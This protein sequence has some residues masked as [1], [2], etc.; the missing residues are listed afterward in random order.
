MT[1]R[2]ANSDA[3]LESELTPLPE[4]AG[5][6]L[7]AARKQ[8]FKLAFSAQQRGLPAV[9][10]LH[11][12]GCDSGIWAG[13]QQDLGE[14]L[15]MYA[16]DLPG[17][18]VNANIDCESVD[19]FYQRFLAEVEPQLP[20]RYAVLGWSL[21]GTLAARIAQR[22][23]RVTQLFTIATNPVFVQQSRWS[24]G[25]PRGAFNSFAKSVEEDGERALQR[26]YALQTGGASSSRRELRLLQSLAKS[27]NFNWQQLSRSLQWLATQ[28]LRDC[29][30]DLR[31]PA[32]HFFGQHD[33][34]VPA[35]A[36]GA[37][38]LNFPHHQVH[39]F[40]A[41][42]H[43]PFCSERERWNKLLV[44]A[45]KSALHSPGSD[46]LDKHAVAMAFSKAAGQYEQ[47][48]LLQRAVGDRLF[49]RLQPFLQRVSQSHS[50]EA[51]SVLDCG[52]GTGL[53]ARQLRT[54]LPAAAQVVEMDLSMGMLHHSKAHLQQS[55]VANAA[56]VLADFDSLPFKN[57]AF[58]AIFA[59][60]SLQWCTDFGGVLQR[61][62]GLL[63]PGGELVLS[64][65]AQGS[66]RELRE[67]W[68]LVD[69]TEHVN[70]FADSNDLYQAA[71]ACGLTLRA[72]KQ[73]KEQLH[74][75]NSTE[76]MASV[77]G[78][79]AGNHLRSRSRGLL[80]VQRYR[81]FLNALNLQRSSDRAL[82]LTYN[83]VLMHLQQAQ[84]HQSQQQAQPNQAK[85]LAAN[86]AAQVAIKK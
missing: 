3:A 35:E 72:F 86:N 4:K 25:M 82:P 48:A 50:E 19:V 74:F 43:L 69:Q 83:V 42:A 8:S 26:F 58:D 2:F 39:Q 9:L 61:L 10:L 78:I 55:G 47:H 29:Y 36:A 1:A 31:V 14:Q 6:V 18:G 60:F 7:A 45:L 67:A 22:S 66:L 62:S 71:N 46:T 56:F 59:N 51:I 12:W 11:G 28:D 16:L 33:A 63:K 41:S 15:D 17:H 75:A 80:G 85:N 57:K 21:G 5:S 32:T 37:L 40:P 70:R 34:L 65:L 77:K 81:R 79:G 23:A 84:Q 44:P 20:V 53:F 54:Q 24:T 30:R 27:G 52:S 38:A 49:A 76:L 73:S 64:T 68:H 13:L